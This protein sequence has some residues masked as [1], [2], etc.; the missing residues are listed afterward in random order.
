[1]NAM[2][3]KLLR[4]AGRFAGAVV[5]T[6]ALDLT[7]AEVLSI[8]HRGNSMF[9]PEN[10]LAAFRSALGKADWVELDGH[11]TR[12][13]HLVVIHDST[14]DRTTDGAGSVSNLTL[15]ELKLLDAG[16]W[17]APEFAGERIPT[18]AEAL[19]AILPQAVPLIERKAGSAAAYVAELRRLGVIDSVAVQAFDWNFLAAAHALE[20]GL[21]LG[22]LGSGALTSAKL[23][24]IAMTGAT[25]VAWEKANVTATELDLVRAAGMDLFVWTVDGPQ[26][27]VF[28]ALGVDG[29]ISNDPASVRTHTHPDTGPASDLRAG[30]VAYWKMDDGLADPFTTAVQD[31]RGANTSTLTRTDG[32]SHWIGGENA[33]FGGSLLVDGARAYVTVPSTPALNINTN[34]VTLSLWVRLT[35]LPSQAPEAYAGIF[36]SVEDCYAL[37]LDR[38]ASELRFKVTDTAGHAARPGI[39]QAAL[40][41]NRWLHVAATYSGNAGLAGGQTVI[42]LDGQAADIHVGHDGSAPTGLKGNVKPNQS[43]AFGRNG[44]QAAYRF[45]GAVDDAAVWSRALSATDIA[46][47]HAIG[48]NGL[49]L[50]ELLFEPT[51]DIV[52]TSLRVSPNGAGI[53]IAFRNLGPWE[54]FWLRRSTNLHGPYLRV[55]GVPPV[56][57]GNGHYRFDCPIAPGGPFEWFRIEGD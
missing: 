33:R 2:F 9:A 42:Y 14:V 53:E 35:A 50:S 22:A 29:I 54:S 51:P 27:G 6:L 30:L 10:T 7:A 19:E 31:S 3:L 25:F 13:G 41:T 38:N 24:E 28:A 8:G 47:I 16:F 52:F 4:T 40:A 43:A 44:T 26:I 32:A 23:A 15:A 48:T 17:F 49:P 11:I 34:E 39:P 1:M 36:D 5:V 21:R 37:Y 12:D 55:P 45:V 46:R 20:P 56:A 18:L 57:L